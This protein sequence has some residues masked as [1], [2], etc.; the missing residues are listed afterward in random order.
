MGS[1]RLMKWRQAQTKEKLHEVAVKGGKNSVKKRVELKTMR[2]TMIE[3]L[4]LMVKHPEL[5]PTLQAYGFDGKSGKLTGEQAIAIG[6]I[7]GASSGSAQCYRNILDVLEPKEAKG[8]E[9]MYQKLD[10]VLDSI[11]E[12]AK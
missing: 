3:M 9:E 8:E 12:S 2:E 1:D 7:V 11:K 4:S 10:E 6:Q 5:I